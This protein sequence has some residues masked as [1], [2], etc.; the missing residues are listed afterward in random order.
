[1]L[2]S[3]AIQF[4]IIL[5]VLLFINGCT[6]DEPRS[7]PPTPLREKDPMSVICE[8]QQEFKELRKPVF[9]K[10]KYHKPWTETRIAAGTTHFAEYYEV[11]LSKEAY[12]FLEKHSPLEISTSLSPLV[13]EDENGADALTIMYAMAFHGKR[14]NLDPKFPQ[15]IFAKYKDLPFPKEYLAQLLPRYTS[16]ELQEEI[17]QNERKWDHERRLQ[18]LKG[19]QYSWRFINEKRIPN[20]LA[21]KIMKIWD[22]LAAIKP[23]WNNPQWFN[24]PTLNIGIRNFESVLNATPVYP[25][26]GE[27][28]QKFQQAHNSELAATVLL[29]RANIKALGIYLNIYKKYWPIYT[30]NWPPT[31]IP[32]HQEYLYRYD[33][34][35]E[36]VTTVH[37]YCK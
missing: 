18:Y 22:D 24:C 36:V 10:I 8:I 16:P 20:T 12:K 4:K 13:I 19:N 11:F 35:N 28:F 29:S 33:M 2:L 14:R 9:T 37:S 27:K 31:G 34:D 23:K 7:G 6:G 15:F 3:H 1:M 32:R 21:Q 25:T 26:V 17:L 30:K 5:I